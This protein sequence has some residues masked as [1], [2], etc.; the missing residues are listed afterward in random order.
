MLLLNSSTFPFRNK[1]FLS[2]E[3]SKK[4]SFCLVW[5]P[6]AAVWRGQAKI[7]GPQVQVYSC[8][9][10]QEANTLSPGSA[11]SLKDFLGLDQSQPFFGI[12][13]LK[14]NLL[15]QEIFFA[16]L[17]FEKANW[18]P[19]WRFQGRIFKTLQLWNPQELFWM[20]RTFNWISGLIV[21]RT[22]NKI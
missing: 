5:T 9:R 15:F 10:P 11:R 14:I 21:P 18:D 19:A 8:N 16:M 6:T 12:L 7:N 1:L 2:T 22:T 13:L 20:Q 17:L 3:T 4:K